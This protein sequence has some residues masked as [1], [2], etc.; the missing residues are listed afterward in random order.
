VKGSTLQGA[1]HTLLGPHFVIS[2]PESWGLLTEDALRR[3]MGNL[4]ICCSCLQLPRAGQA[5]FQYCHIHKVVG[6]GD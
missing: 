6:R 3:K 5:P 2:G 4:L 1:I